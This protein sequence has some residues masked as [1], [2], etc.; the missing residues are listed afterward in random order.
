LKIFRST[1][2]EVPYDTCVEVEQ[3]IEASENN[4]KVKIYARVLVERDSQKG[5]IIGKGGAMLKSIGTRARKDIQILLG[6]PVH[7]EL[8]VTVQ[9]QWADNPRILREQGIE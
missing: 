8:H 2:Q 9:A 4:G 7:L 6:V 5:I 1:H 3:F